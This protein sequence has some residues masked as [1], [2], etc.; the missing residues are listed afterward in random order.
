M[1]AID[2][3]RK[4]HKASE[5][6]GVGR[7]A[8]RIRRARA[9]CARAIRQ[10][11]KSFAALIVASVVV[12]C[13]V[14]WPFT[15]AHL[16]AMAVLNWWSGAAGAVGHRQVGDGAGA[17]EEVRFATEAGVVPRTDFYVPVRLRDAFGSE[18][19]AVGWWCCMECII[20]GI[21]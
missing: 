3:E 17:I 9:A 18:W 15:K 14:A 2:W 10:R 4:R 20:L 8:Q 6:G 19:V 16:Q 7:L 11:R 13:A 1:Q 5:A 21:E 12:M